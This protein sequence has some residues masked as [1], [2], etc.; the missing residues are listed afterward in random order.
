M[1]PS[2]HSPGLAF[3]RLDLHLHTPAS[4][5]FQDRA[6]TPAQVVEAAVGAGLAGIAVTDHNS[7]AWIDEVKAAAQGNPLVVFP[8][9][10]ITCQGGKSGLHI[11][12][13]L[14]P[15]EG[16]VQVEAL[17][18]E[19]GLQPEDHGSQ[20]ALV[21]KTPSEVLEV[22]SRR[23]GLGV[24][25]HANSSRGAL[26][27][28]RGGQRTR[29]FK[30][31]HLF[32]VEGT[33]FEDA[34][35]KTQGKRVVD[36]LN[37][38]DANYPKRAVY[39]ASD[40]P[41][42]DGSGN[43][44]LEGIGT[45]CAYFKLD[46]ITLEGLRQC[47]SDPDVRIRQDFE[48][49]VKVYPRIVS[50]CISS[51]FLDGVSAEFHEGLNSILG[52]KGAG[53]SLLIEFLRFAL[54]QAP[55]NKDILAD[56]SGKL[57]IRLQQ[58]GTVEV[59]LADETG[60]TYTVKR[61]LNTA[62]PSTFID[63]AHSEIARLF[64]VLF[65]SQNEIIK[66]AE[67]SA[68]QIAFIDRFFDFRSY[69]VSIGQL[70]SDLAALD[71][72]YADCLRSLEENAVLTKSIASATL[73]LNKLNAALT[74]PVFVEYQTLELKERAFRDQVSFVTEVVTAVD[75]ARTDLQSR[76]VPTLPE[77]LSEDPALKRVR[78]SGQTAK[79][80]LLAALE[81]ASNEARNSLAAVT[82]EHAAWRPVFDA[83][84][85]KYEETVQR[86]GGNYKD[87]AA[88]RAKLVKEL[89]DFNKRHV[90]TKAR[91]DRI[92]TTADE[93]NARLEDLRKTYAAYSEER[94]AKCAKFESESHG[95]LKLE[96]HEASDRDAFR[97]TLLSLKRGSYLRDSEV[98]SITQGVDPSGFIK[99]LVQYAV[100][101]DPT[102]LTE[103]AAAAK[104]E[105]DR[106][107]TLAD[108]LLGSLEYEA[109]LQ[110]Q[111]KAMPE[112]RPI[113][114]YCVGDNVFE[115]L[116]QLSI[117]QKCTAMLIMAL[118]DG[119]M[120]VVIDQPEDSL[121][122]RSVWEDMCRRIRVGKEGRQFVFT[123]HNASL[124]VASDSDKF[125]IMEGGATSGRVVYSGSMDHDPV[126]DEVLRYLEG[127]PATYKMK[128]LKYNAARRLNE[129]A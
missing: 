59:V 72:T 119:V 51:G 1:C 3:K 19:L 26:C 29:L 8:G 67:S 6:V 35:K 34:E 79:D 89:D 99:S 63:P 17:L 129:G 127:G 103:V 15:S 44:G 78:A 48:L 68:D 107:R 55:E 70:E 13:L 10:E 12:A 24:L 87:L 121:D 11:I 116:G 83:G 69:R 92:K 31:P 110:L 38:S 23:G 114:Q 86:E 66:I 25:A 60:K 62:G 101:H 84:R 82:A 52:S 42:S 90:S 18:A 16:K 50:V 71:K 64:P 45:R 53:K 120:P 125:L 88:K 124:A 2:P 58:F 76:A 40:N 80:N 85:I 46:R 22:I 37:G 105:L 117:G 75:S 113:I 39:Q 7:G 126:S 14:D 28:M 74:N 104:I 61:T 20:D 115:P 32:G 112:D 21:D 4:A 9:V 123:T 128:S 27:D 30:S 54:N 36:L 109:L 73:E 91:A 5:C 65:L 94:R 49:A 33:D 57:A 77:S 100:R 122:I 97:T 111:Y 102:S 95:R 106:M 41:L 98:E 108:F 81:N 93:R 43:H 56:H 96:L 47:F 118:S